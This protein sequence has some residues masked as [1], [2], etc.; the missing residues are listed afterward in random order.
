[1]NE[2]EE[3]GEYAGVMELPEIPFNFTLGFVTALTNHLNTQMAKVLTFQTFGYTDKD[4]ERDIH[5]GFYHAFLML[6]FDTSRTLEG[7]E[8]GIVEKVFNFTRSGD[9]GQR[10]PELIPLANEYIS[11]LYRQGIINPGVPA[12]DIED[13][14]FSDS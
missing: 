14:L 3:T 8:P 11:A 10:I 7:P 4:Q 9:A 2:T 1:M 13:E 6:V 5:A 12:Q